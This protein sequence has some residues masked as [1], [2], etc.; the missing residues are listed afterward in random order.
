MKSVGE[1]NFF[2][3]KGDD[4][5]ILQT[6]PL[7]K[8]NDIIFSFQYHPLLSRPL[9]L[10]LIQKNRSPSMSTNDGR[11]GERRESTMEERERIWGKKEGKKSGEGKGRG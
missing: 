6:L 3:G 11:G 10:L 5:M 2:R 4:E 8:W 7:N 9:L 1:K